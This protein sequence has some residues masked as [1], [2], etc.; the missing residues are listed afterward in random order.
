MK[1]NIFL[2][3]KTH[4]EQVVW[5][6]LITKRPSTDNGAHCPSAITCKPLAI[7]HLQKS[8]EAFRT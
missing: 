5:K 8:G 3:S 4:P 6:S 7:I 2:V 1:R